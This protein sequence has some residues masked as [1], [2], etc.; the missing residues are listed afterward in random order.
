MP[1]QHPPQSTTLEGCRKWTDG[2]KNADAHTDRD[3]VIIHGVGKK[4]F[5]KEKALKWKDDIGGNNIRKGTSD[6]TRDPVSNEGLL[7][8]KRLEMN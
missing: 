6:Q 5:L 3:G 1:R 8:G 7:K 2:P 4:V